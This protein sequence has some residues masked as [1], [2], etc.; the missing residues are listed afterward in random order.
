MLRQMM[1]TSNGYDR[2]AARAMIERFSAGW[3]V[4]EMGHEIWLLEE[5]GEAA[6]FYQLIPHGRDQE[7][8]L[9]FTAD[10]FQGRGVGRRLFEHMLERAG[11][12]SA[13]TVIIKSNPEAADFYRRMGAIDIGVDPP[14]QEITWERPTLARPL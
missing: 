7:L 14:G 11:L 13:E 4:P 1:A 10:A 2:P 9:F 12:L 6:G 3:V 5:N 8:D